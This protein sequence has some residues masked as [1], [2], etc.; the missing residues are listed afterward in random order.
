LLAVAASGAL[1]LQAHAR[2][3][4]V[5][6]PDRDATQLTIYNSVDLT[7]VRETRTLT[8]KKGVN[9]LEFSWANTLI[10]PTSVEFR[11][12][13]QADKVDV[14]DVSFPPRVTNT[15]EWRI[16]SEVAG[17]VTVEIRYFTSGIRWNADYIAEADRT[18]QAMTLAGYV[19]V[20]N[21]SGEDYENAQVRLVVGKV[22]L[23]EEIAQLAGW[24]G[25]KDMDLGTKLRFR[26]EM[27]KAVET[28]EVADMAIAV[29]GSA[30]G[31]VAPPVVMVKEGM[32]EYFLYTVGGRDTI[33]T[34][35]A[36]RMP[37]FRAHAVPVA[38]YYQ[39]ESE[40]WG[41]QV[42]RHYRFK[43]DKESKLGTEPLPDGVVKAVRQ[44]SAD[45]LLAFTGATSVKYIP[46][47]EE[48]EMELG[49]DREVLVKPR[50][51]NWIKE[52]FRYNKHGDIAGWTV[53]ETWEIELQN[54]KDIPIVLD[55]R[56][57][58]AGD[59]TLKTAAAFEKVDA[60]KVKFVQPLQPR[61]K[62]TLTY[63]LTTRYGTNVTR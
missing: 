2:I 53:R 10:D 15:L 59:W 36:K 43:N 52:D 7:L 60:T 24:R 46:V 14:L 17:P 12:V 20:D 29:G 3:N 21:Q 40:R 37:S 48:V 32:S 13:T 25:G 30:S 1:A 42:I 18:E 62:Q 55:V 16:K 44:V 35:W 31:R 54:S 27:L 33:P 39:F 22:R 11:A 50:L 41:E 4:V 51:M 61:A 26:Q 19:R 23:V 5:T 28:L 63:E 6:L 47:N 49:N 8:F 57:N 38:S 45:S 34:G 58:F 56:R 9:R